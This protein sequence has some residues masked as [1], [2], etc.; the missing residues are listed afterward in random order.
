ML[1]VFPSIVDCRHQGSSL[2][3]EVMA[4]VFVKTLTGKIITITDDN[5]TE[6]TVSG[7]KSKIQDREGAILI[8]FHIDGSL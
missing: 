3:F 4:K 6:M 1:V 7:L 8:P 2:S 5:L